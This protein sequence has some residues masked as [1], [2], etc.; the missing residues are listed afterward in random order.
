MYDFNQDIAKWSYQNCTLHKIPL[1]TDEFPN[2]IY[3]NTSDNEGNSIKE[4][5]KFP[6]FAN[7]ENVV[8]IRDNGSY[9]RAYQT[10]DNK[11]GDVCT[12]TYDVFILEK[13]PMSQRGIKFSNGGLYIYEGTE[14]PV[15]N[16]ATPLHM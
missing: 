12:F 7:K 13:M 9:S 2:P 1:T 8:E 6:N 5:V 16:D 10:L 3:K 15:M 11:I 14:Y 4:V